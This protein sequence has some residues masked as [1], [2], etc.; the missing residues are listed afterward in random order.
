MVSCYLMKGTSLEGQEENTAWG[1]YVVYFS[2]NDKKS[3]L[4]DKP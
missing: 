1:V 2:S 4:Y 3:Y